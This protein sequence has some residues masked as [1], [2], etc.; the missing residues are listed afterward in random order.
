MK[1]KNMPHGRKKKTPAGI[2]L[3]ALIVSS[4][5][6]NTSGEQRRL[7]FG[8]PTRTISHFPVIVAHNYGFYRAEGLEAQLIVMRPVL[9]LQALIAA[10]LDFITVPGIAARAAIAGAPVRIVMTTSIAPEHTLVA[11]SAIRDMKDLK[12]KRFGVA[13]VGDITDVIARLS[14][15]KFKLV[16]DRDVI[17][18]SIGESR[19]RFLALQTDQIDATWLSPPQNKQ[20]ARMGFRELIHM[21]DITSIHTV[22]LSTNIRKIQNE[23]DLIVRAIKA[24]LRA[25]RLLK[26]NKKVFLQILAKE[27]G[28]EDGDLAE[29]VYEDAIKL[30]SD[31][32]VPSEF[33]IAETIARTK[34]AQGI[35]GEIRLSDIADFRF[36][37]KALT[38]LKH[39]Q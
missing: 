29:L 30:Y 24:T 4:V 7:R 38:E 6:T 13:S 25:I 39:Q 9:S 35:S 28:I 36:A 12:G 5:P 16:P 14:L 22:G 17:I 3:L 33:S 11:K 32:G 1:G 26:T 15:I 27:S 18:R 19:I 2:I 34:E 21:K 8:I 31:T 37:E 20:A 23:P 10:D